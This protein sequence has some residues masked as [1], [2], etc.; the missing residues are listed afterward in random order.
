MRPKLYLSILICLTGFLHA[1][2]PTTQKYMGDKGTW[3]DPKPAI[4]ART[5]QRLTGRYTVRVG[6]ANSIWTG[7]ILHIKQ[8]R[9]VPVK[10]IFPRLE[11]TAT[12]TVPI[13][14]DNQEPIP[15]QVTLH[16][17]WNRTT[18]RTELGGITL[19]LELD[20]SYK[21]TKQVYLFRGGYD[22][23]TGGF[24]GSYSENGRQ[25]GAFTAVKQ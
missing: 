16:Q 9:E 13:A 21:D 18:A 7:R 24:S 6:G 25:I 2:D 12:I 14:W 20:L 22:P 5:R 1:G 10:D 19:R 23:R 3:E 4:D 8:I 15:I 17:R 11:T